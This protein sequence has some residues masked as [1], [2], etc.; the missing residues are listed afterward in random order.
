MGSFSV[1]QIYSMGLMKIALGAIGALLPQKLKFLFFVVAVCNFWPQTIQADALEH[2]R[3][4][5]IFPN[6]VAGYGIREMLFANGQYVAVG[7]GC[8]T[9]YGSV[10]T[11]TDGLSWT[12]RNHDA[13]GA[14]MSELLSVAYGNGLYVA[15]G[16]MGA[17]YSSTNAIDWVRRSSGSLP[18]LSSVAFG[19]GRFVAVGYPDNSGTASNIFLSLDGLD[20]TQQ[21]SG[22]ATDTGSYIH[23]V[24][25]GNGRFVASDGAIVYSS[26]G[27]RT[28][29]RTN[30]GVGYPINFCNGLFLVGAGPGTNRVSVDG[31]T[32]L[33][34]TNGSGASFGKV[35]YAHGSYF[36]LGYLPSLNARVF[37]TSSDGTNWIQRSA[38]FPASLHVY[39]FVVG[40]HGGVM[41]AVTLN[42]GFQNCFLLTS[43]PLLSLRAQPASLPLRLELSGVVGCPYRIEFLDNLSTSGSNSWQTATNL[44]LPDSPFVWSDPQTPNSLHRFY[45]AALLP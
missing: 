29:T 13:C 11:S 7:D 35:V 36:S 22:S 16:W 38:T 41:P 3:T 19:N 34:Q 17:I 2:W 24:A 43:D 27:G 31:L 32:W 18:W 30:V 15:V 45:R 12:L 23:S 44:S 9:D 39:E 5:Q 10:F 6:P 14:D 8:V 37:L 33:T 42:G 21:R 4:N 28:W 1:Y 25:F 26:A 40:E 20:W